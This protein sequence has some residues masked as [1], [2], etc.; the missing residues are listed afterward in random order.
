[1]AFF[2][3]RLYLSDGNTVFLLKEDESL[4]PVD[5]GEGQSREVGHLHAAH[6]ALWAFGPRLIMRTTDG[7]N[8]IEAES[9]R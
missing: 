1:M 8:W 3:G 6:G 9:T 5:F 7:A 2:H 4:T